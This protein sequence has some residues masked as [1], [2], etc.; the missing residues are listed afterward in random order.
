MS[1][2]GIFGLPGTEEGEL[3]ALAASVEA[4]SEHPVGRGVVEAVAARG[5]TVAPAADFQAIAGHGVRGSAGGRLVWVGSRK[6]MAEAGCSI[7][8]SLEGAAGEFESLGRTAFFVGW[9]GVCRGVLAVADTLKDG[10]E[11]VV[12]ELHAMGIEVAMITGDNARTAGAIAAQVGIDRVLAEVP[13]ADKAAEV[14]RLQGEGRVVAMVGDGVNDAPALVQA[15]LGIAIGSGT[16]V[17]IESSDITLL[18][19]ELDGVVIAIRLARRTFRIILQNLG[20]AFSYNAAAIPLAALGV[21]NPIV[22]G[23]TMALSSVSAVGNSLRLYRVHQ[24]PA[25]PAGV[26]ARRPAADHEVAPPAR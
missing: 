15:D 14:R 4:A 23:A 9:N 16:D 6:L 17:A 24:P 8:P 1:L 21:L 11:H 13:P 3:L 25:D 2:A 5:A 18:G 19:S 10:A 12:S 7:A 20:W 26:A 22:A